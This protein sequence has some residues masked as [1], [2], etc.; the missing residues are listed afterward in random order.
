MSALIVLNAIALICGFAGKNLIMY[1]LF[2]ITWIAFSGKYAKII[3]KLLYERFLAGWES[4]EVVVDLKIT[5]V[6]VTFFA[7]VCIYLGIYFKF[8]GLC[9]IVSMFQCLIHQGVYTYKENSDKN[10]LLIAGMALE[11]L[12]AFF[13]GK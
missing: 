8:C 3:W 11:F 10:R 1:I 9:A 5:N 2:G 6:V 12:L 13:A 4:T 7:M